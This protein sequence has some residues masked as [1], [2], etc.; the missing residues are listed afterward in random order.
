[1]GTGQRQADRARLGLLRAAAAAQVVQAS[2]V[3]LVAVPP[4]IRGRLGEALAGKA[5]V[6]HLVVALAV[7]ADAK[8]HTLD[9]T[10]R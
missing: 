7:R 3:V 4:G 1:M 2:Q 5:D 6:G 9:H 10:S 8:E